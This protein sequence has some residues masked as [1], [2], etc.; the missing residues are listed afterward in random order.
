MLHGWILVCL[1]ILDLTPSSDGTLL[2][3]GSRKESDKDHSFI[4][5]VIKKGN[6]SYTDKQRK[7]SSCNERCFMGTIFSRVREEDIGQ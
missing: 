7:Q 6:S 4:A 1:E 5:N 2:Q 3:I